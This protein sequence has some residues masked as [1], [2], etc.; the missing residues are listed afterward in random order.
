MPRH[1]LF[2]AALLA[3]SAA[4]AYPH[5]DPDAPRPVHDDILFAQADAPSDA[6][7]SVG[8]AAVQGGAIAF[9]SPSSQAPVPL[10]LVA[11]ASRHAVGLLL[12]F[13][14][15]SAIATFLNKS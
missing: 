4:S 9:A 13:G 1:F 8:D 6:A 10:D 12:F 7:P 15:W 2:V 5:P 14:I 11:W 3:C